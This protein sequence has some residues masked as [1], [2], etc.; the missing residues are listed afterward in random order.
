MDLEKHLITF[1]N[2][3]DN[4]QWRRGGLTAFLGQ[5]HNS[6]DPQQ[7]H[8]YAAMSAAVVDHM[9]IGGGL[10]ALFLLYSDKAFSA[11]VFSHSLTYAS[12]MWRATSRRSI[13]NLDLSRDQSSI[14]PAAL[15]QLAMSSLFDQPAVVHQQN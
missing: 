5:P 8:R 10:I 1:S 2:R 14:S 4:L 3:Y 13:S 15:Q 11:C 12:D 9:R 7:D 6:P